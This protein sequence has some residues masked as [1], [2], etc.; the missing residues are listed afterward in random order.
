VEGLQ[1]SES[2]C[3]QLVD[4][5]LALATALLPSL[6]YDRLCES[7]ALARRQG[8]TLKETA[9]A[10]GWLTA[11]RIDALTSPEAVC[12]LGLPETKP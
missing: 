4:G 3:R 7:V 9:V 12:R 6:P 10:Q 8:T 5:S 11:E 1:A 2:R